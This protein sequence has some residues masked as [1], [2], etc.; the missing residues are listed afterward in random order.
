M[1]LQIGPGM[2]H[3]HFKSFLGDAVFVQNVTPLE[4]L[5]Q[6]M[7]HKLYATWKIPLW[8][9]RMML[10]AEAIQVPSTLVLL[11]YSETNYLGE[12]EDKL[13]QILLSSDITKKFELNLL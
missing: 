13:N 5:H 12:M 2:V 1:S 3:L 6:V 9:A 4:P 10:L 8:I 11:V 7:T